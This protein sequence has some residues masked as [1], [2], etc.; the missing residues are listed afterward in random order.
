[1][2]VSDSPVTVRAYLGI[3]CLLRGPAKQDPEGYVSASLLALVE[4]AAAMPN[5]RGSRQIAW[6]LPGLVNDL[7]VGNRTV[8]KEAV[9]MRRR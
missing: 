4:L 5:T 8:V 9:A 2:L 3:L 1:M 6:S 7:P